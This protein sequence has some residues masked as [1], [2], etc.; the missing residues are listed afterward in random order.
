MW[1]EHKDKE[2]VCKMLAGFKVGH[3]GSFPRFSSA[4]LETIREANEAES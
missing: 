1:V 3:T 2:H 4:T